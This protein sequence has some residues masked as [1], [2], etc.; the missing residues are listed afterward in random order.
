MKVIC[1]LNIDA[2]LICFSVY[3]IVLV[4]IQHTT[5]KSYMVNKLLIIKLSEIISWDKAI[6][7]KVKSK[8]D[9]DLG[10]IQS[11][12]NEYIQTKDG[13]VSKNYYYIPK[14]YLEGYDGDHLWVSV[15]KDEVKTRFEKENAPSLAEFDTPEYNDRKTTVQKQYPDFATSIPAYKTPGTSSEQQEDM[16]GMSWDNVI[17]KEVKSADKQDLGKVQSIAKHYIELKEGTISK[18]H[19]FIPKYYIQGYDGHK[20]WA[21]LTKDEIKRKYERDTPPLESEFET[22]EYLEH[23]RTVDTQYPQFLHGIPWMAKEP[24]VSL[25]TPVTHEPLHIAWENVIHKRVMTSDSIDIGDVE[26]VGNEFIVVR[27]GVGNPTI[28]YIPK[29]FI[30][31]YD[32]SCLYVAVPSGLVAGKFARDTE[33]TPE[34]LERLREEQPS[35]PTAG[36]TVTE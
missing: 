28:Y 17:D 24:G 7:K 33:P 3:L 14:Y 34:E 20:L 29:S 10:K 25:Q 13:T 26:R 6:D 18:K 5:D 2:C 19:Y 27:Q 22:S 1:F 30:D 35:R 16:V 32:G 23:R 12:T 11:I 36:S 21:S 8:D 4:Y 9:K 31:N 15:T